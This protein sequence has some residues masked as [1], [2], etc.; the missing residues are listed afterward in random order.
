MISRFP[1][2]LPLPASAALLFALVAACGDGDETPEPEPFPVVGSPTA[3]AL[4][5]PSAVPE[6]GSLSLNGSASNDSA[7]EALTYLWEQVMGPTVTIAD[8]GAANTSATVPEVNENRAVTLRLTVTNR[9]GVESTD[10]VFV[11]IIDG[12]ISPVANAGADQSVNALET[13]TLDGTASSDDDGTLASYLWE[14]VSGP[15]ASLTNPASANPT[16]EAPDV[17]APSS[18]LFRLTVTDTDGL[19]ASDTVVVTVNPVPTQL[20]FVGEP[21]SLLRNTPLTPLVIEVQNSSGA[22]ITQ[23]A[24][25][26]A[27][28]DL[29]VTA[30]G[31]ALEGVTSFTAVEGQVLLDATRYPAVESGVE[32]TATS[33]TL[34][35]AIRT[36]D[37]SWPSVFPAILA[38]E[39]APASAAQLTNGDDPASPFDD[40]VMAFTA[41]GTVDLDLSG[42]ATETINASGEDLVLCRYRTDGTLVWFRHF[43]AADDQSA[44]AMVQTADGDLVVAFALEGT[45]D[46]ARAPPALELSNEG[47]R[48]VGVIRVDGTSGDVEW[49][50]RFGGAADV[51]ATDLALAS[52]GDPVLT[53]FFTGTLDPDP[54]ENSDPRIADGIDAFVLR[55]RETVLAGADGEPLAFANTPSAAGDERFYALALSADDRIHAAGAQ[56][57]D[58]LAW[59]YRITGDGLTPGTITFAGT[60]ATNAI[61]DLE[62]RG[63]SLQAVGVVSGD[64][65]F[66]GDELVLGAGGTDGFFAVF[67]AADDSLAFVRRV[68]GAGD[69]A[70]THLARTDAFDASFILAGTVDGS[71]TLDFGLSQETF[72]VDGGGLGTFL[73]S[74]GFDGRIKWT[75]ELAPT[76]GVNLRALRPQND[77]TLWM[78]ATLQ[79]NG[80]VDLDP[81]ESVVNAGGAA[82]EFWTVH[83]DP[84]LPLVI[85]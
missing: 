7:G 31:A 10:L 85:P 11:T 53:G 61:F 75:S 14:R 35:P 23:G 77:D 63:A 24:G 32:L 54:T 16:F 46:F 6:N 20:A 4:A 81:F 48:N 40:V 34:T 84:A 12:G 37:V 29:A 82:N 79:S 3:V 28:V 64:S 78:F 52:N 30:G 74:L 67:A 26:S 15:D 66:A 25:S 21:M 19:S 9:S 44:V 70:V 59:I 47:V 49:V 69:D 65:D 56:N 43:D 42:T 13:V 1:H 17:S 58:G 39:L 18:I 83:L 71:A 68:A 5:S 38:G 45:V 80:T 51:T 8:A 36:I 27:P 55:L 50:S 33:N 60:G 73:L 72:D 41:S 22:R 62:A 57:D 76:I 2:R